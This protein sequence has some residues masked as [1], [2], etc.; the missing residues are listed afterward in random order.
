LRRDFIAGLHFVEEAV[1][2]LV[3]QNRPA[4]ANRFGNQVRGFL[5]NGRVDLNFAHIHGTCADALQQR[6]TAAGRPFV[7]GGDEPSRSGRYFTTIWLL[8]LKPP[9]A[10]ITLPR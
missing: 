10:T 4:A 8:A 9:V 5:L 7:V 1:P 6:D 3:D 2:L